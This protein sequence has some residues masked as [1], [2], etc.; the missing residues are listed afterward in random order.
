MVN[1]SVRHLLPW[2]GFHGQH[3]DNSDMSKQPLGMCG[4]SCLS[5]VLWGYGGVGALIAYRPPYVMGVGVEE[6]VPC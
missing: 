1:T 3:S 2:S 6:T 5:Y 4:Q